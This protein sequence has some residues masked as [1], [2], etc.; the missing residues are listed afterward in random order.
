MCNQTKA[1]VKNGCGKYSSMKLHRAPSQSNGE[2]QFECGR[3]LVLTSKLDAAA[4][5]EDDYFL[6][7]VGTLR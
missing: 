6:L 4:E 7:W 2:V 1:L 5:P 3:C